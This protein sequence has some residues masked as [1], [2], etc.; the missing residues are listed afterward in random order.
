MRH[1]VIQNILKLSSLNPYKEENRAMRMPHVEK[2]T[3]HQ[4]HQLS[5]IFCSQFRNGGKCIFKFCQYIQKNYEQYLKAVLIALNNLRS[6]S[7]QPI[8]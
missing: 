1:F 5:A 8:F 2:F 3:E 6:Y 4:K 7:F